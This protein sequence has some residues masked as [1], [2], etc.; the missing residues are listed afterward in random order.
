MKS[1]GS[2]LSLRKVQDF[3]FSSFFVSFISVTND[4]KE[5][6]VGTEL[7]ILASYSSFLNPLCMSHRLIKSFTIRIGAVYT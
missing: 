1:S 2:S 3:S 5:E 6:D 7:G 4:Y